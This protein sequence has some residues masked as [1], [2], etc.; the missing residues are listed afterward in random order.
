MSNGLDGEVYD[1]DNGDGMLATEQLNLL[2]LTSSHFSH[3]VT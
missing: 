1:S 3:P 2:L